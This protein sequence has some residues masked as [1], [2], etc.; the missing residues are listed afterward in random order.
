ML[1]PRARTMLLLST[2][3]LII[4]IASSTV[5]IVVMKVASVLQQFCGNA[6]P[7]ASVLPGLSAVDYRHADA[8][9]DHGRVSYSLQP[10]TRDRI[11]PVSR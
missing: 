6:C 3:A 2:P 10:V 4:G 7:L 8:H 11:L 5:L 9:G 1:H